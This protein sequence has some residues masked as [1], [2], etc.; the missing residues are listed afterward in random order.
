MVCVELVYQIVEVVGDRELLKI[1][2]RGLLIDLF[3]VLGLRA[4]VMG[5]TSCLLIHNLD[6]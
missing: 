4:V 5:F 6:N 1:G 3:N 2:S